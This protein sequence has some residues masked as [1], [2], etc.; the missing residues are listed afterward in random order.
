MQR[1]SIAVAWVLHQSFDITMVAYLDDWLLF[2][3]QPIPVPLILQA[4]RR[5][6]ITI[7]HQKSV[8][9][10]TTRLVYL[11]LRIDTITMQL[12]P[13]AACVQHLLQLVSIVPMATRMDLQCIAGYVSW[14]AYAM[15]WPMFMAT[16]ILNRN[17]FWVQQF[18]AKGIL[19]RPRK[20]APRQVSRQLYTD[21]TPQTAAAV[22]IGTPK[23]AYV[24]PLQPPRAI[25]WAEMLAGLE[26]VIWC[27]RRALQEPTTLTLFTDSSVVYATIVRGKGITLRASPLLQNRYFT[28]YQELTKAGHGL[29]A[30]WMPPERNL[31]DPLAR[32][33]PAD[34]A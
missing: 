6:G 25:A 17:T 20:L 28:M 19:R 10:P 3:Q 9:T 24:F 30:R 11:G 23:M 2:S 34:Y 31:A 21:A 12:R 14:L 27:C 26:G 16:L 8:L 22:Y 29:V 1:L 7:N 32:G 15:G 13:T 18:Q 5:M 4:L 33:V